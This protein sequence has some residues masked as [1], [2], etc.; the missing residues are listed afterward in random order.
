MHINHFILCLLVYPLFMPLLLL[1]C[2]LDAWG[3]LLVK[4]DRKTSQEERNKMQSPTLIDRVSE[5]LYRY[6]L[7]IHSVTSSLSLE[8]LPHYFLHSHGRSSWSTNTTT[9]FFLVPLFWIGIRVVTDFL[10]SALKKSSKKNFEKEF[11]V[12]QRGILQDN[13]QRTVDTR[14]LHKSQIVYNPWHTEH[15]WG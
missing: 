11:E 9:F 7:Q 13:D 12:K 10:V 5:R 1:L 6:T 14:I 2:L 4:E 8:T 15:S 3:C